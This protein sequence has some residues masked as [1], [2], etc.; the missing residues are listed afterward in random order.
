M[1][2]STQYRKRRQKKAC[3]TCRRRK[4]RCDIAS[5]GRVP[6]SVCEKSRLEC[7][8]T[9]QWALPKR[10]SRIQAQ[11]GNATS[12][13]GL[14][15]AH[16]PRG[17]DPEGETDTRRRPPH[18]TS[19]WA[20]NDG[21]M[22]IGNSETISVFPVGG[23]P[24]GSNVGS[25]ENRQ[26][27]EL[28]RNGLARFFKHGIGSGI[29]AVFDAME[30]FR[31]AYVGTAVS[32]LAHLVSLRRTLP[33]PTS[34]GSFSNVDRTATS[35]DSPS[36]SNDNQSP[37]S[38]RT[39]PMTSNPA[40]QL[41]GQSLHYPYPPIRP[42]TKW[43]PDSTAWGLSSVENLTADL[44]AFPGRE[45][46]DA[47][48][49][50]YFQY[51][52]PSF[53]VIS[54]PEFM[55]RYWSTENPPPL[56]I[57]Q[58]VL[59][60]GAHACSHPLVASNRNVVKSVLFR[61]ANT[62]LH[63]RH[64]TDRLYL[65]QAA[66]LFTWYIGDGDTVS[67][68]PYF[69]TG[70]AMRIG[71]GMGV[72]RNN[73]ALPLKERLFYKRSW[74]SA[75]TCEVFSSLETGRPCSVRAEDFD[76]SLLTEDDLT[77]QFDGTPKAQPDDVPLEYHLHI[78]NLAIIALDV[79]SLSAP[80]RKATLELD[81]ID[82]RLA[83]WCLEA[84]ISSSAEDAMWPSLLRMHYNIV[85]L[86]LHRS[87]PCNPTSD[88]IR[89][90]AA[91]S[92]VSALERLVV[93]E[94][95]GHCQFTAVGGITAAG[96]QITAELGRAFTNNTALVA[97]NALGRLRRTIRCAKELSHFWPNADAVYQVFSELHTEYE[98]YVTQ[99]LQGESVRTISSQP[100]WSLL[101]A[102]FPSLDFD[103][104]GP[105]QP[106]MSQRPWDEPYDINM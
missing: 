1:D 100:D 79:L 41:D 66:L 7:R 14:R 65:M 9:A 85:L 68:G 60:A 39:S 57:F 97:I 20:R 105:S 62:L 3:D 81:V 38:L 50:A 26:S 78:I 29:W 5:K 54:K 25:T 52:H 83:L 90:N 6:C 106:W 75:F 45:V 30:H 58:A 15:E 87:V 93:L 17:Q 51:I 47:L 23:Y 72:H 42:I 4:V 99:G 49:D 94:G 59:L 67:A 40:V 21:P 22:E 77:E 86:H 28:A 33:R 56:L 80:S 18:T 11:S 19:N 2:T 27:D 36:V 103:L 12:Q 84:G 91:E 69:W 46:R 53:P 24:P 88:K 89:T 82:N 96:I 48:V 44:S 37:F 95:L 34:A 74:W 35:D 43:K 32:N 101:F 104:F 55:T 61:R 64:E 63:L 76:Q 92:I 8:S 73:A 102:D 70:Y 16:G 71:C 98:I 10:A 31:V 13:I